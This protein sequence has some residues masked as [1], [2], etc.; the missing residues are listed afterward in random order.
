MSLFIVALYNYQP[1]GSTSQLFQQSNL[2]VVGVHSFVE[3]CIKRVIQ[4]TN[5]Q[6]F[7]LE[8][9]Q[10]CYTLLFIK[11]QTHTYTIYA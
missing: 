9:Q 4:P 5:L 2:L 6:C 8:W 1:G 7:V 11:T 10:Y 3:F